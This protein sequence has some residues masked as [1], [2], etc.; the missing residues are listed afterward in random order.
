[1]SLNTFLKYRVGN[2][3]KTTKDKVPKHQNN[4]I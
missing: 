3:T 1:M 2:I 4:Y